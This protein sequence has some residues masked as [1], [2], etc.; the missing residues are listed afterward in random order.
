M[1]SFSRRLRAVMLE[2]RQ[3]AFEYKEVSLG[4]RREAYMQHQTQKKRKKIGSSVT[5][6][7]E[8]RGRTKSAKEKFCAEKIIFPINGFMVLSPDNTNILL[9]F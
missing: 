7:K 1:Y 5:K 2:E 9:I 8:G 3:G 4:L 6:E